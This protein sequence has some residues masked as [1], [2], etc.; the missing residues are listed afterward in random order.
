MDGWISCLEVGHF[1]RLMRKDTD[2][3]KQ[4]RGSP[5]P[6]K[7]RNKYPYASYKK[8]YWGKNDLSNKQGSPCYR[9]TNLSTFNPDMITGNLGKDGLS[10]V[11]VHI[12]AH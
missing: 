2:L 3:R 12:S 1:L 10:W 9:K 8:G 7:P 11:D 4:D 5:L 6:F